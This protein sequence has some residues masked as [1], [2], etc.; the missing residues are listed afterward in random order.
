MTWRIMVHGGCGR[1]RPGGLNPDQ[2]E[3]ARMG[4][5]A[6]LDAGEAV[7]AGGGTALDAVE[8]AA[9]VLEDDP[10]FNAGRGSALNYDGAIDLDAAIMDGANRDA[11]AVAGLRTVRCPIS[12]ARAVMEKSSHV[13]LSFEGAEQFAREHGFETVDNSWFETEERRAQLE[14][15]LAAGGEFDADVKYG[16][17]GAVAVDQAGHVAAATS[18]G[19]LTAKRWGRIGDSPLIGAGT[20][21]DDR[22]A[23]VSATGSG[24]FFMRAVA[25]HQVAERLRLGGAS[26]RQAIDDTLADIREMGGTGGLIAV[27]ASGEAQ[28][29]FTTSGMYRGLAGADGRRVA[30]YQEER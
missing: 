23:A 15:V 27:T 6:A 18:T 11:G 17:I 10:V 13:L 7:L 28:W 8:A 9:R 30:V 3:A 14:T 2:D 16:T 1:M 20:Y 29:G 24:E 12:L 5:N 26:L 25:A 19:G 4:L 22:S 21:A